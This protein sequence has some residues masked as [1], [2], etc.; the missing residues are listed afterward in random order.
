ML[1][2]ELNP[3]LTTPRLR[4]EPQVAGHAEAMMKVLNDLRIPSDPPTDLGALRRRFATLEWRRSSDGSL[5][6]LTWTVFLRE[7]AIGTVQASVE[8]AQNSAHVGCLFAP[9][10]WGHGYAAEAM[11]AVLAFLPSLGVSLARADIDTSNLA[12]QRLVSR[13]NFVQVSEVQ[14]TDEFGGV[15]SD[16]FIYE[17]QLPVS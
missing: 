4:L 11:R 5:W 8:H 15:F 9:A 17:L 6:H 12:A 10:V 16:E 7:T 14:D 13:L 1:P 2:T 3:P